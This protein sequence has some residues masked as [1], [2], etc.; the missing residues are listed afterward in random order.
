MK[1]KK[2]H[3]KELI[4]QSI[5]EIK[6][7]DKEAFRKYDKKHKMRGDTEVEIDGKKMKVSQAADVGGPAH[8]KVS[9]KPTI[10]GPKPDGDWNVKS[11]KNATIDGDKV[12]DILGLG[13]NH[14]KYKQAMDYVQ[15]FQGDPTKKKKATKKSKFDP[16][17]NIKSDMPHKQKSDT[18]KDMM[19]ASKKAN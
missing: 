16:A 2:S 8:P 1:I 3:L 19:G 15:K 7:K 5:A 13:T 11:V 10:K 12:G 4:R 6:F 14:P 18:E 17:K 9:K